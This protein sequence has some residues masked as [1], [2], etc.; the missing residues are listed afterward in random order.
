MA[1]IKDISNWRFGR[2]VA[3]Y[4]IEARDRKWSVYWHC[5]C[6]CGNEVDLTEDNLVHGNYKSCGCLRK[7]LKGDIHSQLH[8]VDRTCL[9]WLQGRK[10]R[11][12][13]TSG[14]RGVYKTKNGHYRVNIGFKGKKFY[15][16]TYQKYEDAVQARIDAEKTI[17]DAFLEA[18]R[19][20]NEQKKD[21]GCK[22]EETFV[23]E[24]TRENGGF[25]I[26]TNV[27]N[28]EDVNGEASENAEAPE[29][30]KTK[31]GE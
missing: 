21:E 6:D 20:W 24:V 13:N 4:P 19:L 26:H 31:I 23:F 1:N 10:G 3:L 17:Y 5:R 11:S 22:A 14:F 27:K 7:E 16:G 25:V 2:L 9:E 8:F 30:A 28:S 12:D 15:V 18:Y 29:A